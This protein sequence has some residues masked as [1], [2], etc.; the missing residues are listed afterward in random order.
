MINVGIDWA[1]KHHDV[2]IVNEKGKSLAKFRIEHDS[3][4]FRHLLKKFNDL[5]PDKLNISIAIETNNGLL[6]E[7]LLDSGYSIYPINP[8]AS[9]RAR[10]RYKVS[11]VKDDKLDAWTLANFLRTDKEILRSLQPSSEPIRKLK[12]YVNDRKLLV[13]SH[14]RTMNQLITCLKN[15]YPTAVGLFTHNAD[16]FLR[17]IMQYP[18]PK[19]ASRITR[20]RLEKFLQKN[21]Y[22][23]PLKVDDVWAKLDE[24]MIPVDDWIVESKSIYALS[25]VNQLSLLKKQIKIYDDKINTLMSSH[26]DHKIFKSLPGSGPVLQAQLMVGFGDNRRVFSSYKSVQRQSGTAPITK[27][28][29]KYKIV[30]FRRA[31]NHS[32]RSA[33]H[34]FAFSSVNRSLWAKKYYDEKRAKGF[35]HSHALRCLANI[36]VKIIYT[37]WK[38]N[39]LYDENIRL[40]HM[41]KYK[42]EQPFKA[43]A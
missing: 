20:N 7:Y 4:G 10:D 26:S 23:V 13:V 42:L 37:L 8:L 28:S 5:E 27:Q 21:D 24:P 3:S 29:G 15:Y 12:V 2:C 39:D 40:S 32:F 33:L 11:G 36:W 38:N 31:C 6:V 17:F 30:R 43:I 1:D 9:E 18:T 25:L 16:I 22:S 41:M 14:T 35:T 19:Q 34:N